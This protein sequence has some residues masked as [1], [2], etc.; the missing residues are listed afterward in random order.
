M[1]TASCNL[2]TYIF[3]KHFE[4]INKNHVR[5]KGKQYFKQKIR[6]LWMLL[7]KSMRGKESRDCYSRDKP[8]ALMQNANKMPT[9]CQQNV[10]LHESSLTILHVKSKAKNSKVLDTRPYT[11][12]SLQPKRSRSAQSHT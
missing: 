4:Y 10:W 8:A 6:R 12:D 7:V 1:S 11:K 5:E 3:A 9:E 2:S